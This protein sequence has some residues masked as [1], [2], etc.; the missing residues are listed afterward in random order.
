VSN[1]PDG[2]PP[3][4]PPPLVSNLL[5]GFGVGVGAGGGVTARGVG[6]GVG[7]VVG[8]GVGVGVGYAALSG[9]VTGAGSDCV[10]RFRLC[11]GLRGS[12]SGGTAL[13]V[14]PAAARAALVMLVLVAVGVG[15]DA[16][17]GASRSPL[18][19]IWIASGSTKAATHSSAAP[20]GDTR[21]RSERVRRVRVLR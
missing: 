4:V 17:R 6:T 15:R 10:R 11:L 21:V 1:S 20:R 9:A 14:S 19:V 3:P 12:R 5:G 8:T 7:S 13:E 16:A 2:V 18:R